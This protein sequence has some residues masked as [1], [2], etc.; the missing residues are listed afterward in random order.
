MLPILYRSIVLV[1][2][3]QL[4]RFTTLLR[5]K[6]HLRRLVNVLG[7]SRTS[8]YLQEWEDYDHVGRA[9]EDKSHI[10]EIYKYCTNLIVMDDFARH[11]D[12]W[13]L[14][15]EVNRG[16]ELQ[17]LLIDLLRD[18]A[19]LYKTLSS[20]N[21][22]RFIAFD[23][24]GASAIPISHA[25]RLTLPRL[26]VLS[27]SINHTYTEE[28]D[29]YFGQASLSSL[30]TLQ[31]TLQATS[32]NNSQINTLD[33]LQAIWS[34]HGRRIKTLKIRDRT[35]LTQF[36]GIVTLPPPPS[37]KIDDH[38]LNLQ[39]L[40]VNGDIWKALLAELGSCSTI[41]TLEI[42]DVDLGGDTAGPIA[43]VKQLLSNHVCKRFVNLQRLRLSVRPDLFGREL[44]HRHIINDLE[45]VI[46]QYRASIETRGVTIVSKISDIRTALY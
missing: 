2:S 37:F 24:T 46:E 22:L 31:L 11:G 41:S 32:T 42:S 12:T 34:G 39:Q 27:L 19:D 16:R 3:V 9:V 21:H 44:A 38:L 17:Y 25:P 45:L 6:P 20:F 10:Q 18:H 30:H 5:I 4:K 7:F 14:G 43:R 35:G 26:E 23:L 40:V 33:R 8:T 28:M 29:Q 36:D 13:S 1:K 15:E